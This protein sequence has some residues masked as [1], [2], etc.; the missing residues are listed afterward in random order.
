MHR[1]T[2]EILLQQ[3]IELATK[4]AT[5]IVK[6]MTKYNNTK[7]QGTTTMKDKVQQQQQSTM[8]VQ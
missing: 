7:R 3:K 8:M 6:S 4:S 2:P 5:L 1:D